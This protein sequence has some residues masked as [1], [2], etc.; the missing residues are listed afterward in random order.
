MIIVSAP[1]GADTGLIWPS[2][3]PKS[4]FT[5]LISSNARTPGLQARRRTSLI[6]RAWKRRWFRECL[7]PIPPSKAYQDAHIDHRPVCLKETRF[8][9]AVGIPLAS[10]P[11]HAYQDTQLNTRPVC[12][13]ASGVGDAVGNPAA[14]SANACI[15]RY[16][17]RGQTSLAWESR[18]RRP[19][20]R[21]MLT[22]LSSA[23]L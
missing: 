11:S 6:E 3:G 10:P 1:A 5:S 7:V 12:Q 17:A 13:E 18:P 21:C 14:L 16:L 19:L 4:T 22:F 23:R 2:F 15:L 8:R 20:T 9:D